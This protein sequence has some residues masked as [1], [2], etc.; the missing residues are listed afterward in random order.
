M[1]FTI[2]S[3]AFHN[4]GNIPSIYSRCDG[5][6]RSPP[7]EWSNVPPNAQ[8]LALIVDD[9]DAPDPAKPKLTWVHWV[10]YN[11]PP[12]SSRLPEGVEKQGLPDGTM[13][14]KNDWKHTGY[15]GPSPPIGKHR[16]FF[17]LYA[18]DAV[19]PE[20]GSA[21][22]KKA[23]VDAMQGHILAETELIGKYQDGGK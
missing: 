13:E 20:L 7:L 11:L 21:A 14:A 8:S 6:D 18:L 12:S 5:E 17:K 1:M 15:G 23:L 16:Y 10:L 9:P 4:G 3:P 2:K 19:L 22:T